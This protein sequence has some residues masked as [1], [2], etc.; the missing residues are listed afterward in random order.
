M[1]DCLWG[2]WPEGNVYN[3]FEARGDSEMIGH[4]DVGRR[5]VGQ[6]DVGHETAGLGQ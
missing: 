1:P 4:L 2:V 3:M 6:C 5:Y